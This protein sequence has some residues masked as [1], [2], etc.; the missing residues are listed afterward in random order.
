MISAG[1]ALQA[2]AVLPLVPLTAVTGGTTVLVLA[3]H[4]DDET[5]GCGG[6]IAA[7]SSAGHPPF[8]LGLTDGTGSHPNSKSYPPRRLKAVR[9]QEARDA[10][11]ILGLPSDR[12][13]FLGLRDTAAPI[14][15]EEFEAAVAAIRTV[16]ERIGATTILA[17]WKHDPHCDHLAAHRMAVEVASRGHIRHFAYP[18]W[19]WTL[20]PGTMLQGP[21]PQGMRLDVTRHL[22]AKQRAIA[23]H[24]SQ[25]GGLINDDPA[26]FQLPPNLLEVFS[27]PY[28][29]FLTMDGLADR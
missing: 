20:A 18:V 7:A 28:E 9:E 27:R 19:G 11:A 26:G 3:P 5:L 14:D 2:M 6:L 24:V 25:Y 13:A 16:A 29:T 17:P 23:A 10:V 22:A 1:S 15:G 12:I 4:A 8:V 21:L